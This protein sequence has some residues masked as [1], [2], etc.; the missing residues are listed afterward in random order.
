MR[1]DYFYNMS[2]RTYALKRYFRIMI[3]N[4]SSTEEGSGEIPVALKAT[5][6]IGKLKN[7]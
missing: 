2:E 1:H 7:E 3:L 5:C 6:D 4:E